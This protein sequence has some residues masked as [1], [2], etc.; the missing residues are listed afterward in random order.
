MIKYELGWEPD[1]S[2]YQ[3]DKTWWNI[4]STEVHMDTSILV[5]KYTTIK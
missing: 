2:R 5:H 4:T 3:D 1:M